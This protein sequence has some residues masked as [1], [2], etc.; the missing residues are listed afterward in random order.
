MDCVSSRE[1]RLKPAQV[2][3][4]MKVRQD[5]VVTSHGQPIAGLSS[6]PEGQL[7]E[8]LFATKQAR[9]LRA[10]ARIQRAAVARGL[11]RIPMGEIDAEIQ[12]L[13][14]SRRR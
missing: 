1:L 3:R 13:R 8:V 6:V 4:R 5:L 10:V 11:D 9:A 14:R 12:R 2:W 7:E